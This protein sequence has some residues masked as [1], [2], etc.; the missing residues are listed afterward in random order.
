MDG[1]QMKSA[2]V[3][4][5]AAT[6]KPTRM[7]AAEAILRGAEVNDANLRRAG[8]AG[9]DELDIVGDPHGSASYKK[10]LLRVYLGR[11]VRAAL[12]ESAKRGQ[13]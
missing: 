13:A 8:E 4:V 2:S 12:A 11:A 9:A 7:A 3:I 1:M 6:D 10:H 5:G